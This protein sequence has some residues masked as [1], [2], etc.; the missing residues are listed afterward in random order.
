MERDWVHTVGLLSFLL[1][2]CHAG[3]N[4]NTSNEAIMG[5]TNRYLSNQYPIDLAMSQPPRHLSMFF[6]FFN[7]TA[8]PELCFKWYHG[9]SRAT[10]LYRSLRAHSPNY[11]QPWWPKTPLCRTVLREEASVAGPSLIF[12]T[13]WGWG[14]LLVGGQSR[15]IDNTWHNIFTKLTFF[16][17]GL[18]TVILHRL[19]ILI[20]ITWT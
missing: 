15:Q 9:I 20:K 8:W 1:K 2:T 18:S 7:F 16:V 5:G 17:E 10:H 14:R 4:S 3:M 11:H 13:G 19:M 6:F 12:D